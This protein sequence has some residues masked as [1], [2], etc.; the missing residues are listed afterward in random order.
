MSGYPFG[1]LDGT[2]SV[3]ISRDTE[4]MFENLEID[5]KLVNPDIRFDIIYKLDKTA[6]P[7][8]PD[9]R[10]YYQK[11]MDLEFVIKQVDFYKKR[12][13]E[14]KVIDTEVLYEITASKMVNESE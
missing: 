2:E 1:S 7:V 9:D 5:G 6:L 10:V 4:S 13:Y 3:K 12:G 11:I 14:I 8:D